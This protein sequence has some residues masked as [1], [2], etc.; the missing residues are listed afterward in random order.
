MLMAIAM[1]ILSTV[2]LDELGD[3]TFLL[4]RVA[5]LIISQ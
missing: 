1:G 5:G 2:I 3:Q 4:R